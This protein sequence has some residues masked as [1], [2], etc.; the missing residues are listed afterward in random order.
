MSPK[1]KTS[2]FKPITYETKPVPE[3]IIKSVLE[4]FHTWNSEIVSEGLIIIILYL[5]SRGVH[6][7]LFVMENMGIMDYMA[8]GIKMEPQY[9]RIILLTSKFQNSERYH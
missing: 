9:S 6:H 7:V 2:D 5:L 8:N 3:L 4:H 1:P